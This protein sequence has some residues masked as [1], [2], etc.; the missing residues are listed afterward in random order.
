MDSLPAG[1]LCLSGAITSPLVSPWSRAV[2]ARALP[3]HFAL[4][5][6]ERGERAG[7]E[8][9]PQVVY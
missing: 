4:G 3:Q 2:A 9:L 8:S 5:G 6:G 7:D 1:H